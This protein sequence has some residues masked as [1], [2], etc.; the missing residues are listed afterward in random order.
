MNFLQA[1][2]LGIIQGLTEF[3]PVSSSGHLV[4]AQH[5]LGIEAGS[6]IS[7]EI[8]LHLGTL[9]A[10]LVFFIR[11]IWDLIV[12]LFSWKS[13]LDGE[14]HRK[15][16]ATIAY[17]II[18]TFT[19]G[20]FYLVFKDLLKSAYQSPIFVA[21]MLLITGL[22]IFAS[23]FVKNSSI[24]SSNIGFIKSVFIGLAQ[25]LAIIPGISR[26][27]TTI[28]TSLFC[29]VKRKDAAHFSFLLSIPAIMAANIGEMNQL[30]SLN[31]SVLHI[32]IAGFIAAFISGYMVI[33]F[34]IRLIQS[35]SLKYFAFY[36]WLVGAIAISLLLIG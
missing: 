13:G 33:A 9:L 19:T 10:V 26:S 5:F 18:A 17:L 34:L 30:R 29:G 1:V 27:G 24:P 25:G 8:F 11:Q 2:F 35:G 32:Y 21:F 6:D 14:T 12:S 3:I 23:D 4:L 28:S 31:P 36:V 16:R 7:F 22:I 15:N 20:V